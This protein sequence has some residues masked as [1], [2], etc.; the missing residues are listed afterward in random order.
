MK[1]VW[2]VESISTETWCSASGAM[3]DLA[4]LVTPVAWEPEGARPLETTLS[5]SHVES[6]TCMNSEGGSSVRDKGKLRHEAAWG[7]AQP[8]P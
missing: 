4:I 2:Y 1:S 7:S 3:T 6:A 8:M 5:T